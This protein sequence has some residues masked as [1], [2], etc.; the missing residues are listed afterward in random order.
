MRAWPR[1]GRRMAARK[2][3]GLVLC[4]QGVAPPR[5]PPGEGKIRYQPGVKVPEE[6]IPITSLE[7]PRVLLDA[8]KG[9]T[10]VDRRALRDPARHLIHRRLLRTACGRA[11]CLGVSRALVG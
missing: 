5:R 10:F 11:G 2:R 4:G 9:T 7:T 8:C 1:A 3:R 6:P